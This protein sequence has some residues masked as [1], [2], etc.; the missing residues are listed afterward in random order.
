MADYTLVTEATRIFV[1]GGKLIEEL[2]GRVNTKTDDVS[3]AHM[4]A[5]PGWSEP[6]QTPEFAEITIM[7]RGRMRVQ[8]G[9]ATLELKAGHAIR[10]E[11]GV[12]VHYANPYD[13]PSEY[14]A[15]C[16]PAFGLDIA[17]RDEE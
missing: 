15:I 13:E 17:H 12:R 8:I 5:P 2:F 11:P 1:P 6:A 10:T 16:L 14:Y 7:V 9:D 4:V 3:V